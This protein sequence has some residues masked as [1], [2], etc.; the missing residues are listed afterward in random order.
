[1]TRV[2]T[3]N[4]I[5]LVHLVGL[6]G[7][8]PMA[9][10]S[11]SSTTTSSGADADAAASGVDGA[12]GDGAATDAGLTIDGGGDGGIIP[13]SPAGTQLTWLLGLLNGPQD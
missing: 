6:V 13:S 9:A 2:R 3:R 7:L 4:P 5:V 12:T 8:L 11:S 1:M 10:C